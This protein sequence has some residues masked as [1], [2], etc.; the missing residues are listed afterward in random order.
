MGHAS[1]SRGAFFE[2]FGG[3]DE[4]SFALN[5]FWIFE[6]RFQSNLDFL[7]VIKKNLSRHSGLIFEIEQKNESMPKTEH[8]MH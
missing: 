1:R 8:S 3:E 5:D 2:I 7:T 4:T 6:M